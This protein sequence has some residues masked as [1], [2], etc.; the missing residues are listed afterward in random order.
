MNKHSVVKRLD[1]KWLLIG[2]IVLVCVIAVVCVILLLG[3]GGHGDGSG[4]HSAVSGDN[5]SQV[6]DAQNEAYAMSETSAHYYAGEAVPALKIGRITAVVN[7]MYYTNGGHLCIS[8]T[9]GNG[10]DKV[11]KLESLDV[12]LENGYTDAVTVDCRVTNVPQDF[13]ISAGGMKACQVFVEPELLKVTNDTF[14][15]PVVRIT[16]NGTAS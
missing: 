12:L 7:E 3:K 13:T 16:V 15:A 1:R 5:S 14:E 8:M 9:L 11:M 4:N 10:T 2:A 6:S